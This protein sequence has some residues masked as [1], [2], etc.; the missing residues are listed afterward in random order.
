MLSRD[1]ADA[2]RALGARGR[3]AGATRSASPRPPAALAGRDAVVHL[4]GETSPSA[5]AT[6]RSGASATRASSAPATSWPGW[7]RRA[8]PARARLPRRSATTARAAT[9]ALDEST[10][11]AAGDFLAE[12]VRGLGARGARG[13]GARRARRA[14]RTGVVLDRERRGAG[15]DAAVLPAGRRRAG[16]RRATSTCRGSTST[17]WS[18]SSCAR[19]TTPTLGGP[20]QR[21]RARARD[22]QGASRARSAARCTGPRSRPC[23]AFAAAPAL[24]RDGRDRD[25]RPARGAGARLPS[26]ATSSP[27]DLDEALR[28]ARAAG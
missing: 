16:G 24:R 10:P 13:R 18:A 25:H 8:A 27:P 7:R 11:P 14:V 22:Q 23:P 19:S 21:H 6:T 9:S 12:V 2:A 4:A 1:P 17:T 28:A 3:S 20:G 26:S 15:E 5:G